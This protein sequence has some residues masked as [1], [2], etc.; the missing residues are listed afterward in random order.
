MTLTILLLLLCP[1]FTTETDLGPDRSPPP[2]RLE[3]FAPRERSKLRSALE[4]A[5]E[6]LTENERCADLFDELS[7]DGATLLAQA[8]LARPATL[9]ERKLCARNVALFTTIGGRQI[10][11]CRSA[12]QLERRTL[13]TL[14]VHEAMHLGGQPESPAVEG[15]PTSRELTLRVR[16]AC[17]F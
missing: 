9:L 15:A 10:S 11:V 14:L 4:L 17:S 12:F 8:R 5:R 6:E 3:V 1:A 7:D 2:S 13:A 16:K